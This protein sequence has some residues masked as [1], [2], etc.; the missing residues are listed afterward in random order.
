MASDAV[1]MRKYNADRNRGF[2]LL[3]VLVALAIVTIALVGLVRTGAQATDTTAYLERRTFAHWVAMNQFAQLQAAGLRLR[4]GRTQGTD[5][6]AGLKWRWQRTVKA[7]PD[8]LLVQ[9]E[10]VVGREDEPQLAVLTGYL[11]SGE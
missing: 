3:E 10:F 2:T 11:P 9:V 4:K 6:M 5:E 8:P 7:T 1:S